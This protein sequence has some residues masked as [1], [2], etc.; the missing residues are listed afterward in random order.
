VLHDVFAVPFD[1]I[2]PIVGRTPAATRQLAS[3]GRRRV[4]GAPVPDTDLDGQWAV[5]DA[6]L[7][8]S[9]DGDFERL[10]AILDP[11]VVL[12]SDGGD[13]RPRL[14]TVVRGREA[15]ASSAML[16]RRLAAGATRA[17]VNGTP[18]GVVRGPDGRVF[19]VLAF[20]V[21]RGHVV[22]ID[23]LADPDRLARIDVDL[24]AG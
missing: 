1:D 12:R 4:Q 18:G 24:A 14:G 8:A 23:V 15:V 3:R 17:L 21:A 2:A 20:T 10:V 19:S 5:V 16:F 22:A 6:F 7:A 11:S 9:R 13:A